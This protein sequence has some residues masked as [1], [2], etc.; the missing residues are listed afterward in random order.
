MNFRKTY[1]EFVVENLNSNLLKEK[2]GD[3]Y[4]KGCAMIYFE[5][6]NISEFHEMISEEDLYTMEGDRS[7]GL[8][9]EPH[10][11]LL[12]GLAKEVT[13]EEVFEKIKDFKINEISLTKVSSFNNDNYDVLKWDV[14]S[15]ILFK[16]NS[17]LVELPHET[18]F[19]NYHPHAT[20][21]YLKPGSAAKYIKQM[22]GNKLN[23]IPTHIVYSAPDGEK[24]TKNIQN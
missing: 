21:A 9:D 16:M 7:Y 20:I 1:G 3:S 14:D 2:A 5:F 13:P 4:S 10:I 8:E 19:P 24:F 11:T 18:D 17:A 22:S 23:V 15:P 6:P 12:Y